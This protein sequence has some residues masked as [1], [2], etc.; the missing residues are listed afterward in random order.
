MS[1]PALRAASTALLFSCALLCPGAGRAQTAPM[2]V[3]VDATR[4]TQK[5]YRVRVVLPA[6]PGPF[7]FVYPKWIPGYHGPVGPIEDVVSLRVS[8][9][10]S[11]L[12]WR[13]DLV[14]P[15]AV[16]TTVPAGA[17][18]V[19]VDFDLVGADSH[20]GQNE[21]VSTAQLAI[22]EFSN[23]VVYPQGATAT[24][25][26]VEASLTLPSGWTF[27]TALPVKSQS[28]ATVTFAPASL[29]TLLDSPVIAGAHEKAF[30]L[31]DREELDAASD[32][33][34]GLALTPNFL[35][36]MKHLVAEGPALYGGRHY[37]DYHFLLSL[38]D[39]IGGEG[40]EH[41]ESSDDRAAEEYAAD[42]AKFRLSY[43][44]LPHEY[45][46][47]WNGKYRRPADL[48]P[49]DYQEPE[50]TDLLWI[51]E[52][53]NEY[54]G[55]KLATRARLSSV[56]DQLDELAL[57]AA[58]MDVESGR[59]WRPVRDT[60][61]AAAMLY[62]APSRYY[63]LRRS[64]GDFYAE[65]DLIWLDADV[66]IR[67]LTQGAK[68]LDDFCKLWG[69]GTDTTSVPSVRPYELSDVYALL[70]RVV[71]YDWAAFFAQRIAT[72]EPRADLAGITAG[73][74]DLVY[75]DTPSDLEKA[76]NDDGK[77]DDARF[78][79]GFEV[80]TDG[81]AAGTIS[82]TLPDS[83]AFA[84]G[85]ADGMRIVAVDGRAF[86]KDVFDRAL[87]AHTG[88]SAALELIVANG[89]FFKVLGLDAHAGPRFPH[90]TRR[91]GSADE[92]RAIYAPLT[93]APGAGS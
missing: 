24:G 66:T 82:N 48:S 70:E 2:I 57:T 27:G 61:D 25:T 44:L 53:L 10:G 86:S 14:D 15:Y 30:P 60:A 46:H 47:S 73:G 90:L 35:A 36:G 79:L 31:G 33:D 68:S 41:H 71:P 51:Y 62:E 88:S 22:V 78:S 21:A 23:L 54:N 80:S 37:R 29:Y 38:S 45:S 4:A 17:S 3:A 43:D 72:V 16:H 89:D 58:S 28:G 19:T 81:A 87:R 52:G 74:Y 83:P 18:N 39:A 13:R 64:A 9:G 1:V 49:A 26:Q 65:G 59:R 75:T 20:D 92:L 77:V 76:Q 8:A 40:I 32:S 7:T 11:P 84:A 6:A 67:R 5:L 50:L 63:E 93:F 69:D 91:A 42:D 55:E 34:S 85:I 56:A 12:E